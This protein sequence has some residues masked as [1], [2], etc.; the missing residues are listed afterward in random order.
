MTKVKNVVFFE[1]LVKWTERYFDLTVQ[2]KLKKSEGTSL[3]VDELIRRMYRSIGIGPRSTVWT[4]FLVNSHLTCT[5][6]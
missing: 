4:F 1:R 2:N 3:L 6:L 5:G